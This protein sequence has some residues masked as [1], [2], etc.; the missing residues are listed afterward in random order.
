VLL[1][2]EHVCRGRSAKL[3][4]PYIGPYEII[5]IDDANITLRLPKNRQ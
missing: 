1:H 5:A 4:Q 3:N 2:D